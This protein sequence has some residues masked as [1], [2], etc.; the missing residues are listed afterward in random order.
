MLDFVHVVWVLPSDSV[1]FKTL[2]TLFKAIFVKSSSVLRL[3]SGV[4]KAV[5]ARMKASNVEAQKVKS[6]I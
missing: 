4:E 6:S 5:T 2:Y 1:L 3:V